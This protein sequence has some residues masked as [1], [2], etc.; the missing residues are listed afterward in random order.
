MTV[1]SI[2]AITLSVTNMTRSVDF[3]RST[4]GLHLLYGGASDSFTSFQIGPSFLNLISNVN[5]EIHWWGRVILYVDQVDVL[6][7]FVFIPRY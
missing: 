7:K 5:T 2:S 4:I 3:Y 1:T 6:Y